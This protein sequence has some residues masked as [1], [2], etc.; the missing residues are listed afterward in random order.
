MLS[1]QAIQPC[2]V[3]EM[4]WMSLD[5]E[6][7]ENNEYLLLMVDKASRFPFSFLLPPKHADGTV[8]ELLQLCLTFGVSKS[9]GPDG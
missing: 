3:L 8:R 7:L 9:I 4:D 2:D 6:S 1:G 5:I